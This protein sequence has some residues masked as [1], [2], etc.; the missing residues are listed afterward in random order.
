MVG[1]PTATCLPLTTISKALFIG[2]ILNKVLTILDIEL[3][4]NSWDVYSGEMFR[5][6]NI[7]QELLVSR[8]HLQRPGNS[9]M[10]SATRKEKL[11]DSWT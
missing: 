2:T 7:G 11:L 5:H 8:V 3:I 6:F 1:F 10:L 4:R 9:A